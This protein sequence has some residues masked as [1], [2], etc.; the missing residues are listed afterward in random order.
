[1]ETFSTIKHWSERLLNQHSQN[2]ALYQTI[3]MS[4]EPVIPSDPVL[5]HKACLISLGQPPA[6]KV[7]A[8]DAHDPPVVSEDVNAKRLAEKYHAN[9]VVSFSA[10]ET[11]L[12][13]HP[14]PFEQ[15]WEIPITVCKN[16]DGA[17]APLNII[18]IDKPFKQKVIYPLEASQVFH[19]A[20]LKQFLYINPTSPIEV[21]SRDKSVERFLQ[22]GVE[23]NAGNESS[24]R[25][26]GLDDSASDADALLEL[27]TFGSGLMLPLPKKASQCKEAVP[28]DQISLE[29]INE[30]DVTVSSASSQG[31]CLDSKV[32]HALNEDRQRNDQFQ[33]VDANRIE[34]SSNQ[35][36]QLHNEKGGK[37]DNQT[38]PSETTCAKPEGTLLS[39][40]FSCNTAQ[41][42]SVI[43]CEKMQ[44]DFKDNVALADVIRESPQSPDP[45]NAEDVIRES[46]LSPDGDNVE[47]VTRDSPQSPDHDNAGDNI[48]ESPQSPDCDNLKDIIRE[49]PQSPDHD[50]AGD[51]TRDSPLSPDHDKAGLEKT[52]AQFA[53]EITE[54]LAQGTC[55]D[56]PQSP[57]HPDIAEHDEKS[58]NRKGDKKL[59][60]GDSSLLSPSQGNQP[61]LKYSS[62]SEVEGELIIDGIEEVTTKQLNLSD[63]M[64]ELTSI[65]DEEKSNLSNI[66]TRRSKS[67]QMSTV[68]ED[69]D[70]EDDDC[71]I[72]TR[73][74]SARLRK[75]DASP[76][77]RTQVKKM[78]KRDDKI[79][80]KEL[81][82]E[83]KAESIPAVKENDDGTDS[84]LTA[85]ASKKQQRLITKDEDTVQCSDSKAE[86]ISNPTKPI[87]IKRTSTSIDVSQAKKPRAKNISKS[88]SAKNIKGGGMSSTIDTIMKL[89]EALHT[90]RQ[91]KV[92]N[93]SSP[94]VNS[95]DNKGESKQNPFPLS[96]EN[97]DDY[98]PPKDGNVSYNLWRLGKMNVL[99]RTRDDGVVSQGGESYHQRF[100]VTVIPKIE[101]QTHFGYEQS[102][103]SELCQIWS[104]LFIRP[105]SKVIRGRINAMTSQLMKLEW[106]DLNSQLWAQCPLN[107]ARSMKMVHAIF[108]KLQGLPQGK[109]LLSHSS[110]DTHASVHLAL[111]PGSKKRV[112]YDLHTAHSQPSL[113]PTPPGALPWIP[114][115]PNIPFHKNIE[116]K[117][118]PL[119]FP[120]RLPGMKLAPK[121]NSAKKNKGKKKKKN[122]AHAS[123]STNSIGP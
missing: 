43:D 1:M 31:I 15:Q 3:G 35:D 10:L 23:F 73:R 62:A 85:S 77:D 37:P 116:Q 72:V 30:K 51:V 36:E 97:P 79:E 82:K 65:A 92:P 115:D 19:I 60:R 67:I 71:G 55:V 122:N 120:P 112:T 94:Q 27:E 119:T 84:K 81:E 76:P 17:T 56:S 86:A 103:V 45:D 22:S 106:L 104:N 38:A 59:I 107:P 89:Q 113:Q 21:D 47:D 34:V 4:V 42:T 9:I 50:N 70:N 7:Q 5:K 75:A 18:Y 80:E 6:M 108:D 49:S 8:V 109:Y 40:N 118:V 26:D 66:T 93:T 91:Q 90:R 123:K 11:L 111:E 54:P 52:I 69:S 105:G 110:G 41:E 96:P 83:G 100:P 12:N 68:G 58:Q 2:Y 25:A 46:P 61:T 121:L 33:I 99:I 102:G 39:E 29:K 44:C 64:K 88:Q 117:T 78:K 53:G 95:S 114:L 16:G 24:I 87:A 32:H 98:Q 20:T 28:P 101:H 63:K 74:R 13:T 48:R 14:Q 57:P